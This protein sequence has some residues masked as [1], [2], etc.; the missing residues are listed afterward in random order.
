[1]RKINIANAKKRDAILGFEAKPTRPK[2]RQVLQDGSEKRNVKILKSTL[3]T[4]LSELSKKFSDLEDLSQEIIQSEI[5]C[6]IETTGLMLGPTKKI[7]ASKDNKLVF[8][9]KQIEV[10]KDSKGEEKSRKPLEQKES[11]VAAEKIPISWS[12]KYMPKEAAIKKFVFAKHYQIRHVNGLTFDFLFDMAKELSDKNALMFVGG[13][14]KGNEP[15][16]LTTGGTPYR[17]FLEGRVKDDTYC[18]ILHLTN[19]ELK[20]FAK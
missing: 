13:G 17:G 11:N 1:M 19:L 20:E 6:D 3:E 15:L 8:N 2:V 7:Y 4:D 10:I 18:L 14:E 12:G 9:V 16:I 5:E